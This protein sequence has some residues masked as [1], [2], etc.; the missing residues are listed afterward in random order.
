MRTLEQLEEEFS[1]LP[2]DDDPRGAV[3]EALILF[4]DMI[5]ILYAPGR[6][7]KPSTAAAIIVA[8]NALNGKVPQGDYQCEEVFPS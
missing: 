4:S 1:H 7:P 3:I 2:W 8:I 6:I 5:R